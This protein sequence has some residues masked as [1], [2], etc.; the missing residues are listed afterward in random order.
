MTIRRALV[1][2]AGGFIGSQLV[3]RLKCEGAWVRGI[4][5]QTPEFSQTYADEFVLGDLREPS[6]CQGAIDLPF[7]EVYQVAADTGGAGYVA[8]GDNDAAFVRN[9]ALINLNVL[10]ACRLARVHRIFY[11]SSASVYRRTNQMNPAQPITAEV[12]AYPAN[13]A[14]DGGWEKLFGER[15]FAAYARSY[16]MEVRIGRLHSVFGEEA[17]W[18]GGRE[19]APAAICRKVAEAEDGGD[20]EIWGDGEQTRSF[21]YIDECLHAVR[22]LMDSDLATPVNIGS[23]EMVSINE[24]AAMVVEIAGKNLRIRHVP[25]PQGVRGRTSDNHLIEDRLEWSPSQPLYA[26]LKRTYRWVHDQVQEAREKAPVRVRRARKASE[27]D[28]MSV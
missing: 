8:T 19:K 18:T 25:G 12:S 16:G 27:D 14:N 2:G 26:G 9:S 15:V 17:A 11:S 10:E 24:L 3:K 23:S 7:D 4:D 13:P 5:R 1:C 28:E 6:V 22:R 20:V 21:L